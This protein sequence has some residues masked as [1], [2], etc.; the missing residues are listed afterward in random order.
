MLLLTFYSKKNIICL[1]VYCD[2]ANG[3]WVLISRFS[4]ADP[5]N[6]LL[7]SGNW[8]YDRIGCTG[9]CTS[10]SNNSDMVNHAFY[11]M[12]GNEFKLTR[13]DD[14]NHRALLTTTSNCLAN[15]S[16][17]TKITQFG[18]F[19]YG[20]ELIFDVKSLELRSHIVCSSDATLSMKLIHFMVKKNLQIN[21][22][23]RNKIFVYRKCFC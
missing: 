6:W 23:R 19:R 4:N 10:P 22:H 7:K 15:Q 13:S 14:V 11:S 8:W 17:Q 18:N 2:L 3:G 16:F 9:N 5:R 1:Q 21:V 20:L 12:K